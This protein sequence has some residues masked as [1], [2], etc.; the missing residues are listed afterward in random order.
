M[1]VG[2]RAPRGRLFGLIWSDPSSS[3]KRRGDRVF[4]GPVAR[5]VEGRDEA[6]RFDDESL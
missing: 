3:Q 4:G 2:V 1:R 6:G 5:G